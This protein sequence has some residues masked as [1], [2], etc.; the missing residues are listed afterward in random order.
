MKSFPASLIILSLISSAAFAQY[1]TLDQ[2]RQR[3]ALLLA[4]DPNDPPFS[5]ID[6]NPPGIDIEIARKIAEHLGVE[7]KPFWAHTQHFS[8]GSKLM[9]KYCDGLMDVPPGSLDVK[10]RGIDYTQPYYGT[11]FILAVRRGEK[12]IH[13]FADLKGMT[14][15]IEA[16]VVAEKLKGHVAKEYPSQE[17]ILVAVDKGEVAVGYVGAL[18]AGWLLKTHP[19]WNVD[20]LKDPAPQ[21]HWNTAIAVRK[22]DKELKAALNKAIQEMLENHEVEPILAKYGAPFYP[23]FN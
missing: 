14:V 1:T 18:Q 20:L 4:L 3:S 22:E 19:K 9:K 5:S 21:D 15:G 23:P 7:L 2:V 8:F 10:V 16:G 6:G 17:A 12:G 11:G 13:N